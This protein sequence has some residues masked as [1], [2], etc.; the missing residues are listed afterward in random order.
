MDA[1][2][3]DAWYEEQKDK[4]TED[5]RK[6]I[7]KARNPDKLKNSYVASM[8]QLHKKY[9][10]LSYSNVSSG[11][12][13]HFFRHRLDMVRQKISGPVEKLKS[14]LWPEKKSRQE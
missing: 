7:E 1:D 14:R 6:K 8:N 11:L 3:I 2:E 10:S 9:E 5:Y 13:K 12:R 4:L